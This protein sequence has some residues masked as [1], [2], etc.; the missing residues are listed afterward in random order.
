MADVSYDAVV[1]GGGH[2]ALIAACYLAYSGLSVAVFEREG[3]LGGGTRS[4][5][6]FIPGFICDPFAIITRIWSHPVYT[7]FK[8]A[9]KGLDFI[10]SESGRG[11]IFP[12]GTC[13]TNYPAVLVADKMTG[14]TVYS[15]ENAEKTFRSIARVSEKDAET[16]RLLDERIRT[17][18]RPAL[19]EVLYSP[20]TLWS[21]KDAIEKLMD[22]PAS[23]FEPIYSV[24]TIEQMARELWE[25]PEMQVLFMRRIQVPTGLWPSDIPGPA[26][27]ALAAGVCLPAV[28]DSIPK[29]GIRALPLAL[30]RA[31][32]EMG[33]Q[34]FLGREVDKVLVENGAAKGVR[35]ADGAEI[36]ARKVVVSG[37]DAEQTILRFLEPDYVSP[38]IARRVRNIIH[39]RATFLWAWVA[40]HEQPQ[41]KAQDYDPDCA[42]LFAKFLLPKDPDYVGSKYEA[43]ARIYGLAKNLMMAMYEIGTL[44]KSRAPE[45]KYLGGFE[46][47][48]GPVRSLSESGWMEVKQKL[49]EEI[50]RQ[51]QL[52]TTNVSKDN[53]IACYIYTPLEISKR[54]IS[55]REG[56]PYMGDG[57]ASQLGRFRPIPELSGY[58]MPVRNLYL[59]SSAA[60]GFGGVKGASGYICY[61]V[62]AQDFGLRKVWEEKGRPY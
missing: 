30:Q 34:V 25:S 7:D 58:R 28:T 33:G 48:T 11:G 18:W 15:E 13:I 35:L 32:S 47:L 16:A 1:I 2:N 20:P 46:I 45:G 6:S 49:C 42:L 5:E 4:D 9:E 23:G 55:M 17:K 8:L 27:M 40:M 52:Y 22:D 54:D 37:V 50:L 43:E 51:W 41:Y 36:E 3:E 60:S 57:V 44:D 38:K 59:A 62:I 26:Y 21:E 10:F 12:D 39:D 61:K 24:M 56:D 53:L 31:L 29:G 14:R 19:A